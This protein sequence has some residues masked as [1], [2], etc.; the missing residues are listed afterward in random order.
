MLK[1]IFRHSRARSFT[2]LGLAALLILSLVSYNQSDPS[3]NLSTVNAPQNLLSYFGSYLADMLYQFAG[4]ASFIIPISFV[5]W[6]YI[7]YKDGSLS[8]KSVKIISLVITIACVSVVL[9]N[10]KVSYFP[11]DGGGVLGIYIV[12][13]IVK[14]LA[15]EQSEYNGVFELII[16]KYVFISLSENKK[17]IILLYFISS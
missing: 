4:F 3:F 17:D 9:S 13:I 10:F 6:S 16:L 7:I 12:T 2:F 8:W 5:A 11:A 14:F 15:V 1:K